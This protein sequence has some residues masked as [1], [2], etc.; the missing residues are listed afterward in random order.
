[1]EEVLAKTMFDED[2]VDEVEMAVL[3]GYYNPQD[4]QRTASN[5]DGTSTFLLKYDDT[6]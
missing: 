2:L 3:D 4:L 1:M 6:L 5:V